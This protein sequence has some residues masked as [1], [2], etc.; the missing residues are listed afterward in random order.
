MKKVFVLVLLLAMIFCSAVMA[1]TI[2]AGVSIESVPKAFFGT[3]QVD[4]QL[5][6]TN[7]YGTFKPVSRD[8][9]NLSRTGDV[10]KLENPFTRASA[11]VEI[12]QTEG[13]V[14]VFAKT[15]SFDNKILRDTVTIRINGDTFGGYN[16]IVLETVSLYDGHILKRDTA[17]YLIKGTKLAGT[18][19][20]EPPMRK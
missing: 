20:I 4:A 7:N 5:E 15:S 10:I 3:W 2:K 8:L 9:W 18:S 16:D 19:V 12:R 1:E 17:K 14:V 13:N 6:K 11:Q